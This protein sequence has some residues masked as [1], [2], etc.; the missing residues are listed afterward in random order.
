MLKQLIDGVNVTEVIEHAIG[1]FHRKGPINP[2]TL[3]KL[4]LIKKYHRD[5]FSRYEDKLLSVM[6][7]FYKLE[8]PRTFLE[9]IYRDLGDS[10]KQRYGRPYTPM[11]ACAYKSIAEKHFYSFSAPTSTG[12]SHLFRELIK[13]YSNDIII[14]VPSRALIAEFYSIVLSLVTKDVLVLQFVENIN[15]HNTS[16]RIFIITPERGVEI[17]KYADEFDIGLFLFDEAQISEESVRG[18]SFDAFVRRAER[19]FP[20]AKKVFAHPFVANPEAQI[21]KHGF[22]ESS[23]A[24]N[25]RQSNVGKIFVAKEKDNSFSYFSPY[26]PTEDVPLES[27]LIADTLKRGGTAL[28]YT[29][30]SKI[31]KGGHIEG[32]GDYIDLCPAIEDKEALR[33]IDSLKKYIGSSDTLPSKQSSFI[34]LMAQGVVVHHG[35]MP[36]KARLLIENFVRSGY[37]KL[38]FATS[39]LNQGINM[40]FDCVF[41]DNFSY[42][43]ALT[44]KNLIGRSGRSSTKREFDYG[45]TIVKRANVATFTTRIRQNVT[46]EKTS[47]LDDDPKNISEDHSDL[48]DAIRTDSFNDDLHL[49]ESQVDRIKESNL[50]SD[51]RY[52][53]DKLVIGEQTITAAQYYALGESARRQVKTKLKK[54]YCSHLKKDSLSTA[55]QTVLSAAIPLLLWKVQGKSFSETL[56]LRYSYLTERDK[57]RALLRQRKTNEISQA[58]FNTQFSKIKIKYS[59]QAEQLPNS[60][61]TSAVPLFPRGTSVN[62][63][64][65]DI[66]VYDTYDFLDKVISLSLSDPLCAAL[67]VYYEDTQDERAKV[68]KNYFKYGTNDETEIWLIKYGFD[69]EDIEWIKSI[70]N[71]VDETGIVF[72][73]DISTLDSEQ[74]EVISR[75]LS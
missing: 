44:L 61:L 24:D 30:K 49:T 41:I 72:S 36:L 19:A 57:R 47:K 75:Y 16:R 38:C 62:D 59:A 50:K 31:Y 74:R 13:E 43:E 33:I 55:E 34:Q 27:D 35:S 4:S 58:E 23:K 37:A 39:T 22:S 40:P 69:P 71:H 70:V 29:S 53:L 54:I 21:E 56:S 8:Q 17:F 12:K 14:V 15:Q 26:S 18:F 65:Y 3:E 20:T 52:V 51:M 6:G 10:I 5:D 9:A 11:Q 32:F 28:I 67:T 48:V 45:Y 1:E 73:D 66:L 60:K 7:L 2:S 42:M 46:L 68:L 25:F 63:F 64:D